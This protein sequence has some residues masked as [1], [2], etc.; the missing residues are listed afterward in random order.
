MI[1]ENEYRK[2]ENLNTNKR[3][4]ESVVEL[5]KLTARYNNLQAYSKVIRN[6]LNDKSEI[7]QNHLSEEK[8]KREFI[9]TSLEQA[10]L[11]IIT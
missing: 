2:K 8:D 9:I 5:E 10:K 11:K 4:S 7:L 1:K 6:Q 3:I